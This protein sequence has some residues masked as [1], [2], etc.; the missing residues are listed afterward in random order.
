M[1][2]LSGIAASTIVET[3]RA[4]LVRELSARPLRRSTRSR[5][6]W[7][8]WAL[9]RRELRS[10]TFV[11]VRSCEWPS[12][13][14]PRQCGRRRRRSVRCYENNQDALQCKQRGDI[15][16]GELLALGNSRRPDH[17]QREGRVRL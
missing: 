7:R 1:N 9:R 17:H 13:V 4:A 2:L 6:R 3:Y 5:Y 16:G 10:R 12:C 8:L 15:V 11:L 14:T